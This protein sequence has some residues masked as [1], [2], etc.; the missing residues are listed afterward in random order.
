[1]GSVAT[2]GKKTILFLFVSAIVPIVLTFAVADEGL[3]I[4]LGYYG[5]ILVAP[6]FAILALI[7]FLMRRHTSAT[8]ALSISALFI[9]L[10]I[11]APFGTYLRHRRNTERAKRLCEALVPVLQERKRTQGGYPV[12]WPPELQVTDP[13]AWMLYRD[14]YPELNV[15]IAYAGDGESFSFLVCPPT[16]VRSNNALTEALIGSL[17]AFRFTSQQSSWSKETL[18]ACQRRPPAGRQGL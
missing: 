10:I 2:T 9:T 15:S 3:N 13:H 7:M 16:S 4:Y 18:N 14:R 12:A 8:L 11:L 1:M 6:L 17:P 5:A